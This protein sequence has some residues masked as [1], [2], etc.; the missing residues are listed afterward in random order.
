MKSKEEH[1]KAVAK[2]LFLVNGF[3]GTTIRA[4]AEK[5]KVNVSM[6]NYYFRSKQA[7]FESIFSSAASIHP[8]LITILVDPELSI[9]QKTERYVEA[10][11]EQLLSNQDLVSFTVGEIRRDPELFISGSNMKDLKRVAS[12]IEELNDAME[13]GDIN[14]IDVKS[15]FIDLAGLVAYP[16]M[17]K[18]LLMHAHNM[19]L[20]GFDVFV[21]D[22]IPHIQKLMRSS[23]VG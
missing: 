13:S 5:A 18:P 17:M 16:F 3:K 14:Q 12:F 22:R 7:L 21:R 6:L 1:I 2:E 9:L 10:Y 15:F 11:T 23:L 4:I 20:E 8:D 19:N